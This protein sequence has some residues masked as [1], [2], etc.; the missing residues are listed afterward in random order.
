MIT[1]IVLAEPYDPADTAVLSSVAVRVLPDIAVVIPVPPA[2]VN[3]SAS[4]IAP[5]PES[6][7]TSTSIAVVCAST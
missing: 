6:P 1:G 7:A 2:I 5:V 3:V 4:V